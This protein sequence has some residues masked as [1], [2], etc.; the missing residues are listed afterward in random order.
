MLVADQITLFLSLLINT[1]CSLYQ[2][3]LIVHVTDSEEGD[4][5]GLLKKC[6]TAKN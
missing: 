1:T 5:G 3:C 6:N 4:M 2:N